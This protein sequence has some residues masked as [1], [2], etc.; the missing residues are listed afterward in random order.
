MVE[1]AKQKLSGADHKGVKF[2]P[3]WDF[4]PVK[5][6]AVPLL[7]IMIGVFNDLI[8]HFTSQVDRH[9]IAHSPDEL[10][11]FEEKEYL[12]QQ[13]KVFRSEVAEWH[14]SKAGNRR[15]T[16]LTN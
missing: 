12:K 5:N 3:Y 6:F 14:K 16:L 4:I 7:H 13:L 8:D 15:S 9:V 11:L 2:E 10:K 1:L